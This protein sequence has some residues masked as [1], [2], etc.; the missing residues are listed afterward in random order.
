T[1][2]GA[3]P[4]LMARTELHIESI[5]GG[6]DGVA[7]AGSLVVFVPRTAPGDD[8]MAEVEPR[9]RFARG[10]L[11]AV[12][13]PSASRVEPPCPHYTRDRCGGC[14][15]QHMAYEA[16][17][18]AKAR[19]VRDALQRI[20]RRE[21][22][23]FEVR[24]S[25]ARWRYRRKLT[26]ALRPRGGGWIA[27]LH[28]FDDPAR[29]FPLDDCPITDERVMAAWREVLTASALLPRA[30]E[31][32]GAVRLDGGVTLVLEGGAAWRESER[33]FEAVP[34]LAALWWM[35]DGGGRPLLHARG[36]E[37]APG[38]SFAQVNAAVAAELGALVVERALAY[39]PAAVVDGYAGL[40]ETAAALASAGARVAA[41][42]LDPDAAAWCGARLPAGSRAIAARVE[43][44]LPEL[45][46]ADVVILNPP[47]AGVDERVTAALESA[48]PRPSAVL[49]VSCNPATLARD[50]ARLPGYRIASLVAFDMFP[51]TA[52]VETVC[53]LVPEAA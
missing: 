19:I 28:P 7:R 44:V 53:E 41:V 31:L 32:R 30:R 5:A 6:G 42:E 21:V 48:E 50:L 43:D 22:P 26:L 35:P 10:R 12:T 52:H 49:Y 40:G 20:G 11:V 8:V 14:Q 37:G 17:L 9:G 18:D 27:G 29:I 39:H 4:G 34:S 2:R 16:Q 15:L 13:R 38:A 33:F 51:Q 24:A 45:L 3:A 23:P 47:R 36:G 1:A 46:P 25:A